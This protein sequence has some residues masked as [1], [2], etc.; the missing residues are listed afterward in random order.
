M[1]K[2]LKT[3]VLFVVLMGL[4]VAA[5]GGDDDD[6]SSESDSTTTAAESSTTVAKATGAITVSAAA[7]LTEAFTQIGTDFKKAN[8]DATVTFNF[9]SS[10]TLATQIQQG[11]PADTFASADEANMDKL[12]SANLVDGEPVVFATNKLVDRH[13]A[14]QPEGRQDVGRPGRPSGRLALRATPSRAASTRRRSCRRRA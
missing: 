13:Q 10:G 1:R 2:V 8:P 6:S 9:G 4:V 3:W 12:V 11:A 5:C 14:R 7:S